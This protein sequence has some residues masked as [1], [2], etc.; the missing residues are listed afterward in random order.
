MPLGSPH[1]ET[2]V[3][4]WEGRFLTLQRD[5]GGRWRLDGPAELE[6][7]AGR[8][9]RIVGVRSRFDLLDVECYELA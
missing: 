4:L 7:L 5:G 2:G 9:V 8:R 6:R 3:L 1:D